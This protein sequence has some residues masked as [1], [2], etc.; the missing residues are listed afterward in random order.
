MRIY[1]SGSVKIRNDFLP[2]KAQIPSHYSRDEIPKSIRKFDVIQKESNQNSLAN[3][4]ELFQPKS[5]M[6]VIIS[7]VEET[8]SYTNN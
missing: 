8:T 1:V 4:M 3:T 5:I 7:L 2:G 6:K